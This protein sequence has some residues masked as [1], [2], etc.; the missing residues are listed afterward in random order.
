MS[1]QARRM[2]L[3]LKRRRGSSTVDLCFFCHEPKHASD[4]RCVNNL[5]FF[6][7][8]NCI[9]TQKSLPVAILRV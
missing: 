7:H 2:E 5:A 8:D 6:V 1:E 4:Q 9:N 3:A